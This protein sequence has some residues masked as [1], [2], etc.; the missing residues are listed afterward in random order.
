MKSLLYKPFSVLVA[1]TILSS[2]S[3]DDDTTI[4]KYINTPN[5]DGSLSVSSIKRSGVSQNAYDWTFEYNSKGNMVNAKSTLQDPLEIAGVENVYRI[6]Y[7]TSNVSVWTSADNP[8]QFSVN[9]AC[10]LATAKSGNTEYSYFYNEEGRLMGWKS[11]NYNTGF[12]ETSTNASKA[13]LLWD[14]GNLVTV[15]YTPLVNIPDE[16]ITYHLEYGS[17]WND[18]GILPEIDTK[19]LGCRGFEFMYYAGMLGKAT[20][21]LISRVMVTYS[22]DTAKNCSYKY[23]GYQ[24]GEHDM[25]RNL[26]SFNYKSE[27]APDQVTVVTFGY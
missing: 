9:D 11:V 16:Y 5:F 14:N 18:N 17:E 10:L 4:D 6:S 22:K 13:E 23:E 15:V 2:C 25:K 7:G 1:L 12:D 8:V 20:K 21:N 19:A 3:G 26:K 24:Y 27:D